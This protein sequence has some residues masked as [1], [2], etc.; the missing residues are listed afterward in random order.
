MTGRRL[1]RCPDGPDPAQQATAAEDVGQLLPSFTSPLP[2]LRQ[3]L[4]L[5][6]SRL[7]GGRGG[8][9]V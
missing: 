9:R 6:P 1:V 7:D 4:A 3:R 8:G 2:V 5:A